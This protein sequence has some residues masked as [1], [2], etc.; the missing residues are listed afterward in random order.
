MA[1]SRADAHQEGQRHGVLQRPRQVV[2]HRHRVAEQLAHRGHQHA[3]RV[4][5]GDR[6]QGRRQRVDRHEG[7]AQEREREHDDEADAHHGVRGA[8]LQAEEDADP[9]HHRREHQDEQEGEQAR[10]DLVGPP[11][12]DQP[13]AEHH[14]DRQD[15]AGE[16]GEEL[17]AQVRAPGGRERAEAVDDALADVGGHRRRRADQAERQRLDEDA[18]DEVLAVVAA[19]RHR[20]AEDVREQQHEHQRLQRD[21]EQLLGDLAD[22]GDLASG[23][24][25]GVA[26]PG[27]EPA[28]RSDVDGSDRGGVGGERGGHATASS[29]S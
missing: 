19:D 12:D 16:L 8:H 1:A 3:H 2:D 23:E 25:H 20:P 15:H 22:V 28:A 17:T 4:P 29:W 5:L 21:V 18:A 11:A 26:P 14:D 7:V 9:H 10:A 27:A 6:L 13:G 24:H